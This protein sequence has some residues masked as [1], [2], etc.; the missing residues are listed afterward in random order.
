MITHPSDP[1]HTSHPSDPIKLALR[2]RRVDAELGPGG[3]GKEWVGKGSGTVRARLA[4]VQFY[5]EIPLKEISEKLKILLKKVKGVNF[6]KEIPLNEFSEKWGEGQF[7][8]RNPF[9]MKT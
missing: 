1:F 2:A 5:K 3:S 7:F 8:K 6:T 9:K 4:W